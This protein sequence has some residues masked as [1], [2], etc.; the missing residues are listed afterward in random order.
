MASKAWEIISLDFIEGLP[1][2]ASVSC[3]LIVVDKFIKF[4]HF[5]P[6]HHPYTASSVAS[7]FMDAVYK[8]HGLPASIISD[9]DLIFISKFWQSLFKLAGTNLWMSSS[10]HLQ[11]DGQTKQVNQCLETFLRCFVHSCPRKWKQWLP[12]AEFWYNKSMHSALG[13]SPFE[14]LYGRATRLLGIDPPSATSRKLEEWL[15]ERSN[16]NDLIR[17]HLVRVQSKLKKQAN[18]R[19]F[20]HEFTVGDMVYMKLQPYV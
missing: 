11:S 12:I 4:A 20:D 10:Y 16:M 1:R 13:R 19:R 7:V 14:A 9:R 3:I 17:Q 6:L 8:L 18:K 2:S 15:V 5:L